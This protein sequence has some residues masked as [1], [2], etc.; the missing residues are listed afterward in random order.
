MK[1]WM[2]DLDS[3][4]WLIMLVI[5]ARVEMSMQKQCEMKGGIYIDDT[6]IDEKAVIELTKK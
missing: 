5:G 4:E 3:T 2:P 6:C 1:R